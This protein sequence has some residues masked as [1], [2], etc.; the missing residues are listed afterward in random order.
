[1]CLR[2]SVLGQPL[3][4]AYVIIAEWVFLAYPQNWS[5][6][7]PTPSLF[8]SKWLLLF[9]FI[10]INIEDFVAH[11]FYKR[12]GKTRCRSKIL[13]AHANVKDLNLI[14]SKMNFIKVHTFTREFEMWKIFD[15]R[16]LGEAGSLYLVI[17]ERF[18]VINFDPR[19]HFNVIQIYFECTLV[20]VYQG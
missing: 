4:A 14:E 15:E 17:I 13:E 5:D 12:R 9:S 3:M 11:R 7:E 16:Y 1:M 6:L 19:M 2:L 10:D 8:N 18:F 20:L